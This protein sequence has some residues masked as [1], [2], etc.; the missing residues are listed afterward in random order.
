[1]WGDLVSIVGLPPHDEP[2][3]RR[4]IVEQMFEDI[5]KVP[6]S[7]NDKSDEEIESI[8]ENFSQRII[9]GDDDLDDEQRAQLGQEVRDESL[10]RHG[11]A[12][13][14]K[15]EQMQN[16]ISYINIAIDKLGIR[17]SL[18]ESAGCPVPAEQPKRLA[19]AIRLLAKVTVL[20]TEGELVWHEIYDAAL[21][22]G[23]MQMGK[24]ATFLLLAILTLEMSSLILPRLDLVVIVSGRPKEPRTQTIDAARV[25]SQWD[26]HTEFQVVSGR[27]SDLSKSTISSHLTG[28]ER[29]WREGRTPVLIVK[30][31]SNVLNCLIQLLDSPPMQGKKG[32]LLQ[33]EADEASVVQKAGKTLV[34][35]DEGVHGK[36][37]EIRDL[38]SGPYVGFTA[39]ENAIMMMPTGSSLFAK[40]IVMLTP[41]AAYKGP[42][43]WLLQTPSEMNR[44]VGDIQQPVTADDALAWRIQSPD[45]IGQFVMDH[46]IATATKRLIH[47]NEV[48]SKALMNISMRKDV[49]D[50]V[51]QSVLRIL[52]RISR[53]VEHYAD[54]GEWPDADIARWWREAGRRQVKRLKHFDLEFNFLRDRDQLNQLTALC[55]E[56]C[57]V[58]TPYVL[59]EATNSDWDENM[60]DVIIIAGAKA[61][62][63]VVFKGLTGIFMPLDPAVNAEDT[64]LQ[65]LR[66]CG[67]RCPIL[68]LPFMWQ[69]MLPAYRNDMR[70]MVQTRM[71]QR[72]LLREYDMANVDMRVNPVDRIL[73]SR[74][75]LTGASRSGRATMGNHGATATTR[76][77]RDRVKVTRN[78]NDMTMISNHEDDNLLELLALLDEHSS[79]VQLAQLERGIVFINVDPR[80]LVDIARFCAD[81]DAIAYLGLQMDLH[82][83]NAKPVNVCFRVR[84]PIEG[85]RMPLEVDKFSDD[86][87]ALL[88]RLG[89]PFDTAFCNRRAIELDEEGNPLVDDEDCIKVKQLVGSYL[90]YGENADLGHD[91]S[92]DG[93]AS[94]GRTGSRLEGDPSL[95]TFGIYRL[96][97]DGAK[98]SD[99][100]LVPGNPPMLIC[101]V[102]P[103]ELAIAQRSVVNQEV[104]ENESA[105]RSMNSGE[106]YAGGE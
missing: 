72:T 60:N 7:F 15:S 106:D 1:V 26:G 19:E 25:L 5:Y 84:K 22:I 43:F 92:L 50:A 93:M 36:V 6:F 37:S 48:I 38:L 35:Y 3:E 85:W 10:R 105:A 8:Y 42:E 83:E 82:L 51:C 45:S 55:L 23:D 21:A 62:R 54:V 57:R 58:T 63:A 40:R 75:A 33:D 2:R 41:G 78:S 11:L 104:V 12:I 17:E 81:P 39:T 86:V 103:D 9:V 101:G 27:Y 59:N 79:E 71:L 80:M 74:C 14:G 68:D 31:D 20:N 90:G 29:C 96:T 67:Y 97:L 56:I 77:V 89:W 100:R 76:P 44:D 95:F 88:R 98:K 99:A 102:V 64:N 53:S 70:K 32:L 65:R 34:E 69:A 49:H 47:G 87:V 46:V 18:L 94:G 4:R 28:I 73:P 24:T 66:Q 13:A 91:L 16:R 30:K 61:G 52:H